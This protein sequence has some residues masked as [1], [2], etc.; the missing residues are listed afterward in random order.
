MYSCDVTSFSSETQNISNQGKERG[1]FISGHGLNVQPYL[2][3]PW[4]PPFSRTIE[5]QD[6]RDCN[7]LA[8]SVSDLR[9]SS[10]LSSLTESDEDELEKISE[11]I[12]VL[13]NR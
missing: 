6:I 8:Y 11:E 3:Q 4:S 7:E 13:E 10:S 5:S 1:H 12:R 2:K 9:E